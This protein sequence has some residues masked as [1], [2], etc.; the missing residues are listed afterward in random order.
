MRW[1][2]FYRAIMSE[3]HLTEP[4]WK[5][6]VAKHQLKDNGLQKAFLAYG[7]LDAAKEP[8]PVAE[9][10]EA[11]T[12][13]AVKL[14]KAN[15]AI[16]EITVYLDEV[17]KEVT[18][19]TARLP[20]LSKEETKSKADVPA[21]PEATEKEQENET[22]F[23]A[24]LISGLK[25]IKAT[26]DGDPI[27]FV[28]CV[29][30][31][32]YGLWLA[33]KANERI[34]PEEKKALT[35]LTGGTRFIMGTCVNE[36]NAH[37]FIVDPV[38]SGLGKNLKQA[39]KEFTGLACKVR[40]RDSEGKT[41]VDADTETAEDEVQSPPL[42]TPTTAATPAPA[43]APALKEQVAPAAPS[44]S[45]TPANDPVAPQ[46][47]IKLSTYLSGKSNL[48]AA[49]ENA[50]KEL[51][52]LQKAIL[53]KCADEPFYKEVEAKSQK[54]FDLLS[55][56]DDSVVDKLEEAG[57]CLDPEVQVELNKK[58][59]ELI[60]KQLA[61]LRGH[62]LAPFVEKNPF[63]KFVIRQPLEVTLSALDKQLS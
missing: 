53:A 56:I 16:K 33:R 47:D 42:Q 1:N 36:N 46:R 20:E 19:T 17:I 61:G 37:T 50:A 10:L 9:A 6:L 48:R 4:P 55:P 43:V 60:A 63:G 8:G 23:K 14:K 18:R 41:V 24:R 22:D 45:A 27:P 31:P 44:T 5:A 15:T 29:A 25:K 7:K 54:L 2:L 49:R 3:K 26:E 32:F 39:I 40:V 12:G 11:I 58:L 59:R 51:Q 35:E 13:L 38:P 30:K 21:T 28:V 57:R 62:A 52:R 34:T